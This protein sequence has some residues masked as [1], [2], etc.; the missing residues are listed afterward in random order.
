MAKLRKFTVTITGLPEIAGGLEAAGDVSKTIVLSH[1]AE[2]WR[3]LYELG[4][5]VAEKALA[6]MELDNELGLSTPSEQPAPSCDGVNPCW[7]VIPQ[8]N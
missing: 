6:G 3:Q 5:V 8:G 2:G 1:K 4:H 7:E